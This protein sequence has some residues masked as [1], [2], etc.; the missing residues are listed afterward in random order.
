[1]IRVIVF[2]LALFLSATSA[3]AQNGGAIGGGSGPCSAFGTTAGTCAQGNDSRITGAVQSGG[4]LG[5]PSSGTLTNATGLPISTGVSGLG[6]GVATALGNAATANGGIQT[7]PAVMLL[8]YA[9]GINCNATGDTP[10][11]LTLPSGAIGW[12]VTGGTTANSSAF[13]YQATGSSATTAKI[14]IYSAASQGGTQLLGQ[15]NPNLSASGTNTASAVTGTI[16]PGINT[17]WTFT[18]IYLNVGTAQGATCTGNF[19]LYGEPA[20]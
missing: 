13:W 5:T 17:L 16:T 4:A 15:T 12:R 8:G 9:D 6:T 11:P 20:F 3:S 7:S 1:V 10:I 19:Y 2:C 14:G 18:T